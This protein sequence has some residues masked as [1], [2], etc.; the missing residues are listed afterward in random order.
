LNA[1]SGRGAS[2][3]REAVRRSGHPSNEITM[4]GADLFPIEGSG[5]SIA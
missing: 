3:Q 4:A 2:G 5:K 1:P